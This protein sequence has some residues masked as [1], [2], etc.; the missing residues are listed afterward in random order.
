MKSI[1]EYNG[2]DKPPCCVVIF[3]AVHDV[4]TPP[5]LTAII[6]IGEPDKPT[7]TFTISRV[8]ETSCESQFHFLITV[9]TF[10]FAVDFVSIDSRPTDYRSSKHAILCVLRS[11]PEYSCLISYG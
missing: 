9:F 7:S 4:S 11:S 5:D 8:A 2:V 3:K 10:I 6:T 1:V